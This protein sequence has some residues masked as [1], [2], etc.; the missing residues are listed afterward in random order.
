MVNAFITLADD[1][2]RR[3]VT[4]CGRS[5]INQFYRPERHP[6]LLSP[7]GHVV[8]AARRRSNG[9]ALVLDFFAKRCSVL[10]LAKKFSREQAHQY[11]KANRGGRDDKKRLARSRRGCPANIGKQAV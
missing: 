2:E 11:D 1:A 4:A 9:E 10:N 7:G 8:R 5:L 6:A 3:L